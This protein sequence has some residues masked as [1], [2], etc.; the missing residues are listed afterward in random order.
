MAYI[1]TSKLVPNIFWILLKSLLEGTIKPLTI[2]N[3]VWNI[4]LYIPKRYINIIFFEEK[5][6][7]PNIIDNIKRI[8]IRD[9]EI[10]SLTPL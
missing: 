3:W 4:F 7:A 1:G 6:K 9:D 2:E 5:A 10:A 8:T